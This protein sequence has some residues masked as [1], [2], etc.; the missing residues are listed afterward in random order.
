MEM[1]I[2]SRP[3]ATP[4]AGRRSGASTSG[5]VVRWKNEISYLTGV[6]AALGPRAITKVSSAGT[7][8]GLVAPASSRTVE[9]KPYLIG[10]AAG[11]RIE[12]GA[13]ERDFGGDLGFDAKV[14]ITS[15]LTADLT[16]NTDF[17]QVE[18][19]TQQINLTRFS[20][21]FPEKRE[22]FSKGRASSASGPRREARRP[23]RRAASGRRASTPVLFFRRRQIGI[24]GGRARCRSSA[25]DGSPG[26]C[27]RLPDRRAGDP[28][29][30]E[31]RR[32]RPGD[33]LSR[34]SG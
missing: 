16:W 26:N 6:P 11:T 9:V 25:A 21:F 3:S 23:A 33:G 17:A 15:G 10:D 31:R 18:A 14:G 22:F 32:R 7:L 29:R 13:L 28:L 2:P 30:R 27:G 4:A 8:V 1:R 5:A 34:C 24:A 12:T 20:L 19:D